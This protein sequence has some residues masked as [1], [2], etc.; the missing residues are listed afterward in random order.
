M[1]YLS[2][3]TKFVD[4]K[5]NQLIAV[6]RSAI[7]KD[8]DYKTQARKIHLFLLLNQEKNFF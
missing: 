4:M 1:F 6:T 2:V 7:W 8:W 3:E 5:S